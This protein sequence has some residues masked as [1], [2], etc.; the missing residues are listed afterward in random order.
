MD[1]RFNDDQLALQGAAMAFCANR[2]PLGAVAERELKPAASQTWKAL[3][4]LGVFGL[5]TGD[6]GDTG[7]VEA[8]IVFEA[9]GTH[10]VTGPVLWSTIA[11][12]LVV[13]AEAGG[14]RVTGVEAVMTADPVVVEHAD[15][16]DVLVVLYPDR[17]ER[18]EQAGLP[19]LRPGEPLDPL[20]PSGVLDAVPSGPVIGD[21]TTADRLRLLGTVFC[22]ASLVGVA[23]GALDVARS[24]ALERE[25]F[26]RPIGSFQAIKHLLADMY[27][28]LELARSATYAAAAITADPRAGDPVRAASVAKLLA[29]EAGIGNGRAAVQILG[30]M[31]FTWDMLPHYYLKRAWVLEHAFGTGSFHGL[32]LGTAVGT[33]V[34]VG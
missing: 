4:E 9:L 16:S 27:V 7:V 26:G 6:S 28:R 19:P 25:Q 22:A 31:G 12:T 23:Q 5:L 13:G 10:L 20:T 29:G 8:A 15:E 21:R 11:A 17:V 14:L 30:G 1:F 18:L 33:E 3:A 32:A 34:L 2:L 24:Y